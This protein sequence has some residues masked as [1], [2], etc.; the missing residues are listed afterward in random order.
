MELKD[1]TFVK[2][3]EPWMPFDDGIPVNDRDSVVARLGALGEYYAAG[4][5]AE[6]EGS[7][8]RRYARA[9]LNCARHM[10]LM[11]WHGERL[12]PTSQGAPDDLDRL[13]AWAAD[14]PRRQPTLF[15]HHSYPWSFALQ[16]CR[17]KIRT[18]DDPADRAALEHVRVQ[19]AAIPHPGGYTHCTVNYERVLREGLTGYRDRI[20]RR[21][22]ECD[23]AAKH[24]LYD[25]LLLVI[26]GAETITSR[27]VNVLE[28][29]PAATDELARRRD[30]LAAALRRVPMSPPRTFYEAMVA[31][32]F[33]FYFEGCDSPGR[34][35]QYL[36]DFYRADRAA[37]LLT[38]DEMV[39]L[40][41]EFWVNIDKTNGWNV[42]LGGSRGADGRS[43][44]NELTYLC[45]E[46]TKNLRRPN[47]ALRIPKDADDRL[48]DKAL[49]VIAT[50]AGLPALYN[51]ELYV[52]ALRDFR[53]GL[54]ETDLREISFG[55]C[56]ETMIQGCSN[57]GSL[58]GNLHIL[59]I[60][61]SSIQRWLTRSGTFETFLTRY[62]QDLKAEIELLCD[63]VRQDSELKHRFYPHMVR[64]LLV[65]DC[66]E[67]GMDFCQ[68]GARYNWEVI[69][70]DGFSNVVDSLY[71]LKALVFDSG[72]IPARKMLQILACNFDGYERTLSH[73]KKL[74]RYG[75]GD[76]D[77]D[78]LARRVAEFAFRRFG[79]Q[80][81]WRGGKFLA[82]CLMFTTYVHRGR[83]V[84]ATPD[85]RR[86]QEPLGDSF[87]PY[88]GRDTNGPT[89]MINSVTSFAHK[90]APGTLV[91]N[92]RVNP[93]LLARPDMK[94]KL[95]ALLETYFARGGMQIQINVIDQA[96]IE[97]A[98]AH[99]ERHA[100]LIIRVGGYSEYFNVLDDTLKR[101]VLERVIHS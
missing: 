74:P 73:I 101:T 67:R 20:T 98:I 38:D 5:F 59:A 4:F 87:G 21:R 39:D 93:E 42:A 40:L 8:Y 66:I 72:E 68:G 45:L 25:S 44:V 29:S 37:G 1:A 96:T 56:T 31:V 61:E 62:E 26:E 51:D 82:S 69:C 24:E 65:D 19:A 43:S 22:A 55:G 49:E 84:G 3:Y 77:V 63:Q 18:L 27:L 52:E 33:I 54:N 34:I 60:L 13:W 23:A 53:L 30:A 94:R 92:M 97:D 80:S 81:A 86:A 7:L 41:R 35:D 78:A 11:G 64:T 12:F 9:L 75:Q 47:A 91:V 99:P 79:E 36:L 76:P 89:A 58:A 50:G 90:L 85:G 32:N 46:A 17:E 70:L 28:K 95:R 57:V 88:Q 83:S 2:T 71:A 48:W 16:Q 6:H 14:D 10:P 100:D 15:Y